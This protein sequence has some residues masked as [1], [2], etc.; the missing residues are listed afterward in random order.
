[1]LCV[2]VC[3]T[4]NAKIYYK[5]SAVAQSYVVYTYIQL[6]HNHKI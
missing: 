2:F 3:K 5:T 6:V 1:M 4:S